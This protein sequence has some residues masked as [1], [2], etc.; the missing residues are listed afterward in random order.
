MALSGSGISKGADDKKPGAN[1]ILNIYDNIVC[2]AGNAISQWG[3]SCHITYNG[4]SVLFDAGTCPDI[5]EHNARAFGVDLP[6]VDIAILSHSHSDHLFGFD[7]FLKVNRKF[8]WYVPNDDNLGG[9]LTVKSPQAG[10][11]DKKYA[12]GL[13]YRHPN[14]RLVAA[15]TDIADGMHLIATSSPLTGWF[16]KYPPH[17]KEAALS[18]LPE[19]SLAL[20][21]SDGRVTLISGCSH[22]KIEEI[23]KAA[24]SHLGKEIALVIGGFHYAPYPDDYVLSI[25]K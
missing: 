7:H 10:V 24:K 21:R 8:A 13:Q 22:S 20:D 9:E 4:K 3:F 1:R 5:L 16:S 19:L 17:D 15:H 14:T 11:S 25:A 23:V 12:C 6:D 2:D 18:G